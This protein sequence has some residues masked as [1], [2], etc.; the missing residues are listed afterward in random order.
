MFWSDDYARS[1]ARRAALPNAWSIDDVRRL[2]ELA[3]RNVSIEAIATTL[4]RSPS[5]IKNKAGLH[6]I[7][8]RARGL[9]K[10]RSA[11]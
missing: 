5:A 4:G 3:A 6:G 1:A 2:R 11:I 10:V 8:L 7:S 9:T